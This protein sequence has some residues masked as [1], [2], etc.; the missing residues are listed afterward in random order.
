M[1][2]TIDKNTGGRHQILTEKYNK[3]KVDGGMICNKC[4]KVRKLSDYG[5]NKSYCIP[6]KR[7][8]EKKKYKRS[9]YKLW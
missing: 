8:S 3:R 1:S 5:E 7:I 4:K 6:C 9:K 2:R